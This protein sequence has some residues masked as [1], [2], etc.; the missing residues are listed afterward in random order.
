MT[1]GKPESGTDHFDGLLIDDERSP[2]SYKKVEGVTGVF[3]DPNTGKLVLIGKPNQFH[4]CDRRGCGSVE[5]KI[6]EFDVDKGL[7]EPIRTHM[8]DDDE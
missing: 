5:H 7:I 1:D 2:S 6:A 3:V 4:N 8:E